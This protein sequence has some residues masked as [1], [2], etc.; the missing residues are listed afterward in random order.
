MKDFKA[1]QVND[2]QLRKDLKDNAKGILESAD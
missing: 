1:L 2:N